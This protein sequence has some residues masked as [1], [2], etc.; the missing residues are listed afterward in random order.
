MDD[1]ETTSTQ[2]GVYVVFLFREDM[3]GVYLTLNQG[4]T[5]LNTRHG[6][7]EARSI[8]RNRATKLEALLP[9]GAQDRHGFKS[10]EEIDLRTNA[11]LGR[12]YEKSTATCKLYE[13]G[14][15]P[16]DELI[17]V[18]LEALLGSYE[19]YLESDLRRAF[20]EDDEGIGESTEPQAP[21]TRA[22]M[23]ELAPSSVQSD[24]SRARAMEALLKYIELR[25]FVFEPWQVAQY[26]TAIR[27]KPFVILA[28]ITG[29]GK[30]KLPR[31]VEEGT[32]GKAELVPVRPDWTDSSEV[33]GY[34]DL[35]GVFRPG[36]VLE[37]AHTATAED[38]IHLTLVIDEMNLA[39][40]EHYFAEVLS[41]IEDRHRVA[42]GGWASSPL[43]QAALKESDSEWGNV[44]IPPNLALVGTVNMDESAHGFSRKV[45]DRAFTLELSDVALGVWTPEPVQARDED[46]SELS[47]NG[48]Q[49]S[50]WP[51][52]AWWP[53]ATRLAELKDPSEADLVL[54][55]RVIQD[56]LTLNKI[57]APAQL[58]VG[59]RTRDEVTLFVL[60]SEEIR[61]FFRS[62]EGDAVDPLDLAVQ[63]K[64]LPR[65]AGGSAGVRRVLLGVMGWATT[66][67]PYLHDED[68][69]VTIDDW[70]AQG[71]PGR[72]VSARFPGVAARTC[73]MWDRLSSEGFTS[74]WL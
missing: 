52:A 38:D 35:E 60:H 22:S 47:L 33:L 25:G 73:L 49:S 11:Q 45:L 20:H 24:F 26:V 62:T 65:I 23:V 71:R 37:V 56:L 15:V 1:R 40:V 69:R 2:E 3:S 19:A 27:T 68:A 43:V 58:Q 64:I 61:D 12:N 46:T 18:D 41:R 42:S 14:N 57:L 28:G 44:R 9:P 70:E 10:G 16:S 48:A 32:G 59:Y 8:L 74:Y 54:I 34:V 7:P 51:V 53:R 31:L 39:R 29:T 72:L 66:G 50:P 6:V 67:S 4:V 21:K 5:K 13:K 36:R 55:D 63:M 17:G 30:S